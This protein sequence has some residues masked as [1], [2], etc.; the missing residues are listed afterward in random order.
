MRKQLEPK[1][2]TWRSRKSKCSLKDYHCFGQ[3][4]KWWGRLWLSKTL[5]Q[6]LRCQQ[7]ALSLKHSSEAALPYVT[8]EG[9]QVK[10]SWDI[11]TGAFPFRPSST[12][13][14]PWKGDVVILTG[15]S[16]KAPIQKMTDKIFGSMCSE[17]SP[18]AFFCGWLGDHFQSHCIG[19]QDK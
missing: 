19:G 18:N 7:F 13:W 12:K 4:M 8:S 14:K 5:L 15:L 1:L 10:V 17:T 6:N 11:S 3:A 16:S 2:D 9:R